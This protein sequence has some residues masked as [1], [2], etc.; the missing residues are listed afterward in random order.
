VG[1][2]QRLIESAGFT[3]VTLSSIPEL[4]AS[5]SV[6][7]LTGIEHPFGQTV[8]NPGDKRGQQAVLRSVLKA[9]EEIE[10]PGGIRHLPFEWEE[11][12]RSHKS[13]PPP[14]AGYMKRHPWHMP[15]LLSRN[16][17]SRT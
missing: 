17:P 5:V 9:V 3:T 11:Q 8:G 13:N 16:P 7:R 10:R 4:T 14:I 6:P 15:R 12:V 1:L 2:A